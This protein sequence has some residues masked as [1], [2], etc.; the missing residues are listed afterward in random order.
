VQ[1]IRV[2]FVTY[3]EIRGTLE[4]HPFRRKKRL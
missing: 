4:V 3:S 1:I 2:N